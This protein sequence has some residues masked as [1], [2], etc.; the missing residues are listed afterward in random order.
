M[1]KKI[2]QQIKR[3]ISPKCEFARECEGYR[4]NRDRNLNSYTRDKI[5]IITPDN[6]AIQ[7]DIYIQVNNSAV[8]DKPS[9]S[10]KQILVRGSRECSLPDFYTVELEQIEVR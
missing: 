8:N 3:S 1:F 9:E 10:Y 5:S 6:K 4:E 7:A 2:I